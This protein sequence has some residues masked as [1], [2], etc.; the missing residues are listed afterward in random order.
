MIST[1]TT[2]TSVW[3]RIEAPG[4][5]GAWQGTVE[6]GEGGQG[7]KSLA[8]EA[9][10]QGGGGGGG[11]SGNWLISQ[12]RRP[13]LPGVKADDNDNNKFDD[14][15]DGGRRA[16][17]NG[18]RADGIGGSPSDNDH[19]DIPPPVMPMFAVKVVMCQTLR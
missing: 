17:S 19:C 11:G 8:G 1:T 13:Q 2:T 5:R 16:G 7:P 15:N 10:P 3:R 18:I 14:D 6:A 12:Q 9:V 4:Q